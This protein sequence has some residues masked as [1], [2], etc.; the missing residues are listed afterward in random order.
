M[1]ALNAR[2]YFSFNPGSGTQTRYVWFELA[3]SSPTSWIGLTDLPTTTAPAGRLLSFTA[4]S[5]YYDVAIADVPAGTYYVEA[6]MIDDRTAMVSEVTAAVVPEASGGA[7]TVVTKARIAATQLT[8]SGTTAEMDVSES[9][10]QTLYARLSNGTGT[11]TTPA[12]VTVQVRP[13]GGTFVPFHALTG[14]TA[15][16]DAWEVDLP[17]DCA[18]VRVVYVAPVGPTGATLDVE[19]GTLVAA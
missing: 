16:S 12:T 2:F 14:S 19:V 10:R 15:A 4:A 8:A 13:S 17:D 9:L 6:R 18:G 5:G 1:P 3:G 11:V 7:I